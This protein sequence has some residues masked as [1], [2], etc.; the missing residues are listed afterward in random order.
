MSEAFY[1]WSA[2]LERTRN[3]LSEEPKRGAMATG[4]ADTR[5]PRLFYTPKTAHM[6]QS[7]FG[8]LFPWIGRRFLSAEN[9][10]R[11]ILLNVRAF[12]QLFRD[13]GVHVEA[14]TSSMQAGEKDKTGN[15]GDILAADTKAEGWIP[16][17]LSE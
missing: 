13:R 1:N 11:T 12:W 14:L 6:S 15:E 17:L 2:L 4:E 5:S 3:L 16:L 10:E 7:D 9:P 8:C